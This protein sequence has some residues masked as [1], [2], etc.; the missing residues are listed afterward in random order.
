VRF[1]DSDSA[2]ELKIKIETLLGVQ[3]GSERPTQTL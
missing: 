2:R 3:L 1:A